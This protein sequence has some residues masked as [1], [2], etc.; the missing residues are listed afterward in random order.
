MLTARPKGAANACLSLLHRA[1]HNAGVLIRPAKEED[2]AVLGR[3]AASLVVLHHDLDPQRFMLFGSREKTEEGYG[4][5][6]VRQAGSDKAFVLVA[7]LDAVLLG[8]VYG[9]LEGRD[10][11]ALR[12]AAGVLQ[13]IFVDEPARRR[14]VARALVE[15]LTARFKERG[16]SRVV[17]STA[18]KNEP[19]QR[20]FEQMGFR[21]TMIEMTREL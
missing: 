5:W 6:L 3:M 10:W 17:L 19:A 20:F 8:Y 9:T 21:R 2:R 4:Q 15:A 18:A 1:R 14:G 12:D 16:E 13:D 11:M 7:E